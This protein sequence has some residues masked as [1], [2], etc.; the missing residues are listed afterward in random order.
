MPKFK[1][2]MND[3]YFIE[4]ETYDE[5]LERSRQLVR[6]IENGKINV[7]RPPW[8]LYFTKNDDLTEIEG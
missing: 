1:L 4:A 6:M 2:A 3:D 5:A 7:S 8:L